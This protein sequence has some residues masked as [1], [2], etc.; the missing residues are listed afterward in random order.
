MID[1]LLLIPDKADIERDGI[2]KVWEEHGGIV[3]R[4]GKFWV[5]PETNGKRIALYGYDSFCLVLA[6]ILELEMCMPKDEWIATLPNEFTKRQIQIVELGNA[7]QMAYPKFIKPV[8]P[9]LFKAAIFETAASLQEITQDISREER[10]IVSDIVSVD[11]EVRSFILDNEVQDL[12]YYEGEGDLTEVKAFIT[13]FLEKTSIVFPPTFVL[14]VGY[15]SQLG[16]FIIEFN[17]TWGA[18]LN[19]CDA[20]KVVNCIRAAAIN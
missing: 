10:L 14:D 6:Q 9:K 2:A 20:A 18:G 17:S 11:K 5:K 3:K 12:A 1:E 8:T 7:H 4:I 19:G 13:G 16:W 15:N